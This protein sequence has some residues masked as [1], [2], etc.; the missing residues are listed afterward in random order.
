MIE[1]VILTPLNIVDVPG[2]NV[3]HGLKASDSEYEGFGE[4]YFS[5]VDRNAVKAWKKHKKMTMN[6][7]VP[8]GRIGL[9]VF[10]AREES[11]SRGS[12]QQIILDRNNYCRITIPPGLWFGFKGIGKNLN[13]LMNLANIEHDPEEGMKK[14]LEEINFD[15]SV[16]K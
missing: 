2:G 9:V 5:S 4:I 7:V 3:Y 13:L 1:G 11:A 8:A 12:F 16:V 14:S 10:D 6:L 15:W